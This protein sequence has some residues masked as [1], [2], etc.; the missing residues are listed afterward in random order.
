MAEK[1]PSEEPNLRDHHSLPPESVTKQF[2]Q[3]VEALNK[4]FKDVQPAEDVCNA[5]IEIYGVS[6]S[7]RRRYLCRLFV[8]QKK[9]TFKNYY[10]F[11][12]KKHVTPSAVTTYYSDIEVSSAKIPAVQFDEESSVESDDA[13]FPSRAEETEAPRSKSKETEAPNLDK[14]ADAAS[15]LSISDVPHTNIMSAEEPRSQLSVSIA[16]TSVDALS[17]SP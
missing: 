7:I 9:K 13:A 5:C 12:V 14:L 2:F 8:R 16:S 10:K 4:N 15:R 3:D 17:I 11:L 6:G 1:G